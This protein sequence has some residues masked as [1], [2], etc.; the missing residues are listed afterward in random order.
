MILSLATAA[1]TTLS[2][3]HPAAPTI[4]RGD[5]C[6]L[7]LTQSS[8]RETRLEIKSNT[9]ADKIEYQIPTATLKAAFH[10]RT[11]K[12]REFKAHRNRETVTLSAGVVP[13]QKPAEDRKVGLWVYIESTK[14]ETTG[15]SIQARVDQKNDLYLI[16]IVSEIYGACLF[17]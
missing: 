2:L 17:E 6:T 4:I 3:P 15:V 8:A 9:T 10:H 14:P 12:G 5:D 13:Y 16:S 7:T 1:I 11:K